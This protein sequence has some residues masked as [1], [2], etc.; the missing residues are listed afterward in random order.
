M[1]DFLQPGP[2][3]TLHL[4]QDREPELIEVELEESAMERRISLVLPCLISEMDGPALKYIVDELKE[5]NYLS[6]IIVTLGPAT[7]EE[8]TKTCAYFQPLKKENRR[9]RLVWNNGRRIS[10]LFDEMRNRGLDAGPDGKGRSAW[11][12]YGYVLS[13][14]DSHVI[15]LHDCDIVSYD[16]NLL[17]RLVY[18]TL[19]PDLN[20]QFSKGYYSRI[21]DRLYGRTTRLLVTPLLRSLITTLGNMPILHYL[22]CFRYPLSGEFSMVADLARVNYLPSDWGLEVGVLTEV[23]RNCSLKRICQVELCHKYEH[24]HQSLSPEDRDKGLNKMAI[25]ISRTIFT[26]L[27]SGG[28]ILGPEFF[29]TLRAVFFKEAL[30]MVNR[31]QDDARINGLKFSRTAEIEAAAL[32]KKR[33]SVENKDD[34]VLVAVISAAIAAHRSR[35]MRVR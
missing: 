18:P 19:M 29:G 33:R 1:S 24:K 21:T 32:Y 34:A 6:E 7:D 13:R 35:K 8:F 27:Y 15:A 26:A 2:I 28:A 16:R 22:T 25:D 4:L 9:V 14:R 31:Y 12:A 23:F 17:N 11:M 5:I 3:A 30:E 20:Y 10:M